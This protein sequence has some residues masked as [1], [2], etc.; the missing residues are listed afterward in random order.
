MTIFY[1]EHKQLKFKLNKFYVNTKIYKI[2]KPVKEI[3]NKYK[4]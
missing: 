2:K 3:I 1:L 4:N